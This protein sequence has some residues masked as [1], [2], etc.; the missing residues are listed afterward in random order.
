[1][2]YVRS[3]G[4]TDPGRRRQNNQDYIAWFQPE[5]RQE[6][7]QN[8]CLYIVADG[9]GGASKG[10]EASRHAT[11]QVMHAYYRDVQVE[12]GERLAQAMRKAGNDIFQHAEASGRFKMATTMVAAVVHGQHL[13][14]A[15][16]GD[17]RAYLIRQ[18]E[19]HQ[20][21]RDHSLVGEMV[22][23]GELTEEE[24]R[25]SRIRNKIT[26]SLGGEADVVV[27]VFSDLP[28]QAGDKIMLCSDGFSQYADRSQIAQL[29]SQ[30]T[31]SEIASRL[32]DFANQSGGSDN[33]SVIVVE[34]SA[35][36]FPE[37]PVSPVE[38]PDDE[39][40]AT[41]TALA[42]RPSPLAFYR[43]LPPVARY[44]FLSALVFLLG[45]FST[46]LLWQIFGPSGTPQPSPAAGEAPAALATQTPTDMVLPL[47]VNQAGVEDPDV[48]AATSTP[49]PVQEEQPVLT[50]DPDSG[51]DLTDN[52]ADPPS[53]DTEEPYPAPD[54]A[55]DAVGVCVY[56]NNKLTDE[57]G[58]RTDLGYILNDVFKLPVLASAGAEG[59]P[60]YVKTQYIDPEPGL[61]CSAEQPEDVVCDHTEGSIYI[62]LN[63]TIEIPNIPKANCDLAG[64]DW[65]PYP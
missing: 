61:R 63:W 18:G 6:Y 33:I 51:T 42:G 39:L 50:E 54:P 10:D 55:A 47:V 25:R 57:P 64:G 31:A 9:V 17:S 16:V 36:P 49:E 19:V 29:T 34:V 4:V 22:R 60:A 5:S 21:T 15:N 24:A 35:E 14:V 46:W 3:H 41:A 56:T 20:V 53:S 8:G 58:Y 23:H 2:L 7:Q 62:G 12:I 28:L 45:M 27:D 38:R 40:L 44:V 26:R 37:A 59:Y 48:S 13:T 30:G 52:E 43:N 1:M 32:V 65:Q 11:K